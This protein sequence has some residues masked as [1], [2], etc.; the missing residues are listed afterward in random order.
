MGAAASSD[1]TSTVNPES[2]KDLKKAVDYIASNYILSQNFQ[3]MKHLA[4][5]EYCDDLV[6][7]TSKVIAENL[8]DQ[9]IHYLSRRIDDGTEVNEMTSENVI[10]T[11]RKALDRLDVR[12]KP[13]KERI[14]IGIAKFYVKIAHIFSAVVTTVNPRYRYTDPSGVKGETYLD[15]KEVIPHGAKID[16]VLDTLCKRRYDALTNNQNFNIDKNTKMIIKP[17]FCA[18]NFDISTGKDRDLYG[19]RGIPELQ[20]LYYDDYD[21]ETGKFRGMTQK[22]RKEVYEKDV[23][24]FYKA[25]TGIKNIPVNSNGEKTVTQFSQIPLRDF[26]K[27]EGCRKKGTDDNPGAFVK[28]SGYTGSLKEKLFREY[29]EHVAE[30]MKTTEKNQNKLLDIIDRLFAFRIDPKDEKK[31]IVINP[32]LDA[33]SLQEVADLARKLIVE[34]YIGCEKDFIKGLHIFESIVGKQILD[35]AAQRARALESPLLEE[36]F[37]DETQ[38]PDDKISQNPPPASTERPTQRAKTEMSDSYSPMDD[39]EEEDTTRIIPSKPL[40]PQIDPGSEWSTG[41]DSAIQVGGASTSDPYMPVGEI[42]GGNA[43]KVYY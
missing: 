38:T 9:E 20:E 11:K 23:E 17:D 27:S 30:M 42:I 13:R 14:C 15:N 16:P 22:M 33:E 32:D 18:M 6:I 41:Q 39:E 24:T 35:T 4:N 12:N 21:Y 36:Q 19:E 25:F 3:D 34:L 8:N 26:H 37:V 43:M 10:Y 7:L 40:P 5:H 29:A 1:T 2:K 31:E 28:P